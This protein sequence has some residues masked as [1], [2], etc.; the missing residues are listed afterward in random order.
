MYTYINWDKEFKNSPIKPTYCCTFI[1][2]LGS[3]SCGMIGATIASAYIGNGALSGSSIL[4]SVPTNFIFG[5]L[6]DVYFLEKTSEKPPR[7]IYAALPVTMVLGNACCGYLAGASCATAFKVASI[8]TG[9]DL[10]CVGAC[11][12]C[13]FRPDPYFEIKNEEQKPILRYKHPVSPPLDK[14]FAQP[15]DGI[16]SRDEV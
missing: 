9:L 7:W 10:A 13:G 14:V 5:R 4:W 2:A 1:T 11:M 8:S 6:L 15:E 12:L 16:M 3:V